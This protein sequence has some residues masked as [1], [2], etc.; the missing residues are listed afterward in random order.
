ML[1]EPCRL[2]V[3]LARMAEQSA[4]LLQAAQ[5]LEEVEALRQRL[6]FVRGRPR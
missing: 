6:A 3:G 4:S 2:A 1:A 5:Q